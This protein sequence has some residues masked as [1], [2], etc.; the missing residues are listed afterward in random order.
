V[1]KKFSAL[2]QRLLFIAG[3]LF[4]C[5]QTAT[6]QMIQSSAIGN[7]PAKEQLCAARAKDTIPGPTVPFE[8]DSRYV[9]RARAL[10]PDVT[11]I[12]IDGGSPQLVECYLREGTGRYEPASYSPEQSYWHLIKP[13]QF[14]PGINTSKGISMAANVC[15][16]A[17]RATFKN[18]NFDH[19]VY[20]AVVELGGPLHPGTQI[21]GKSAVRY[22][23][24]VE[25]TSFYK[26]ASGP[27]LT[28]I[29]FVCLLSPTLEL[30][31]IRAK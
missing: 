19:S 16:E 26:A 17:A 27:D 15:L 12:A 23:I 24:T 3:C 11:F 7:D 25:G 22:D 30:K 20:T 8:I 9:A 4:L 2:K 18:P 13:K 1:R 31:A 21:A 10:Y 14:E 5:S 28:A 6:A 29:K